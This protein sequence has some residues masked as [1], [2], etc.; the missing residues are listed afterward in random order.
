MPVLAAV[1]HRPGVTPLEAAMARRA[2]AGPESRASAWRSADG[3]VSLRVTHEPWECAAWLAGEPVVARLGAV[4]AIADATLYQRAELARGLA[5][6]GVPVPP[7]APAATLVAAVYRAHGARALLEL[8]GDVAFVLWDA[9]RDELLLGRDFA[10]TRP[11]YVAVERDRVIVASTLEGARASGAGPRDFDRLGLAEAASGLVDPS[12]RTA[13]AGVRN[14]PPGRVLRVDDALRIGDAAR[15][16]AP[17]FERGS[18]TSF[19]DAAHELREVLR[20]AVAD[21]MAPDTTAVWM[22]GG[23]DSTAVFASARSTTTA[24]VADAV[25]PVSVSYQVG[26]RGR[27][28]EIIERIL[29][30]HGARARWIDG[31]ALPLLGDV[32]ADAP[33]RDD[34]FAAMYDGFFRAASHEA[35][36]AGARVALS[37]HGGDVL[38]DSSLIYFADLLAGFHLRTYATEWH[39]AREAMWQPMEVIAESLAPLVPEGLARLAARALGRRKERVHEPAPW[40]RPAVSRAIADTGWIPLERRAGESRSSAVARWTL[41]YPFFTKSQAA[42]AAAARSEEIEYRMPLL[43]RRGLALAATR[44]RWE[45][46]QGVRCKSLLRAAMKGLLPDDVLLPRL[47]KTGLTRDYLMR[48]VQREFPRHAEALRRE[49]VLADLGIIDSSALARAVD[50]CTRDEGGWVAG[51]LYFTFQTEYWLRGRAG[52]GAAAASS[53]TDSAPTRRAGASADIHP[54]RQGT[55]RP[56]LGRTIAGESGTRLG[57]A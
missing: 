22:S 46:R 56:R 5:A 18:T 3:R 7:D 38:F 48:S 43:D 47:Y 27:E 25:V 28:D 9:E 6:A 36:L 33:R 17:T 29:A 57:R 53:T 23:Y 55:A 40:L 14:V 52:L 1:L 21:R 34:P 8:N 16:E 24:G 50:A 2:A 4:A 31:G 42:A 41:A 26:D 35:R 51:Q 39:A 20:A 10:A 44:P 45:K 32:G 19:T 37:G 49:S 12:G 54:V 30:H 15:W 11:L 13:Y